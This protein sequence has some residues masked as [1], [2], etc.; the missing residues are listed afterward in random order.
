MMTEAEHEWVQRGGA[1][2]RLTWRGDDVPDEN[3]IEELFDAGPDLRNPLGLVG[4]GL[5]PEAV[6]DACLVIYIAA[7]RRF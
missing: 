5:L 6:S 4:P 3:W 1:E 2:S 7:I